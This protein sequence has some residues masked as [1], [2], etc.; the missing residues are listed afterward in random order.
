MAG[1]FV[2]GLLAPLHELQ[3]SVGPGVFSGDDPAR[4]LRDAGRMLTDVVAAGTSAADQMGSAWSGVAA[5][6]ATRTMLTA[7][8][9]ADEIAAQV[10][11][12][13]GRVNGASDAVARARAELARIV[14]EFTGTATA[15][16]GQLPQSAGALVEAA[17]SALDEAAGVVT[18]LEAELDG[19]A[20]AIAAPTTAASGAESATSPATSPASLMSS[21]LRMRAEKSDG[22]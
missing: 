13:A 21:T 18:E 17:R 14:D 15:L 3:A 7:F 22:H 5:D 2:A 10:S 6:A 11:A 20:A 8:R 19:H 16:E 9:G 12:T 1:A 4:T